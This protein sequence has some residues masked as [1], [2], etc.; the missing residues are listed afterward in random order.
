MNKIKNKLMKEYKRR[1]PRGYWFSPDTMIFFDSK[2]DEN[3]FFEKDKDIFFISSEKNKHSSRL[4]SIRKMDKNGII[5]TIN[6]FR[7][8]SSIDEAEIAFKKLI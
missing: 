6:S 1:K 4:W 7:Q 8:Y 2:I 3:N 5:D